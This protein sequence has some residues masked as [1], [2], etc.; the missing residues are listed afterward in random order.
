[1]PEHMISVHPEKLSL[2][3]VR[4]S[5]YVSAYFKMCDGIEVSLCVCLSCRKGIMSNPADSA[6]SRWTNKH[7][8]NACKLA[9]NA[10]YNSLKQQIL[11]AKQIIHEPI[12]SVLAPPIETSKPSNFI[13]VWEQLKQQ[14]RLI[15]LLDEAESFM[16]EDYDT[17][18]V[19]DR[20]PIFEF[21]PKDGIEMLLMR[22]LYCRKELN[23][24]KDAKYKMENETDIEMNKAMREIEKLQLQ[25]SNLMDDNKEFY[26][27]MFALEDNNRSLR[28]QVLVLQDDNTELHKRVRQLEKENIRYKN[29]YPPLQQEEIHEEQI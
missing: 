6:G 23:K 15:P 16:K 11:D 20:P 9:H 13:D 19:D 1:M 26:V 29:T 8:N 4:Y 7:E 22:L 3:P 5:H 27:K 18:D 25:L 17:T 12:P 21:N 10:L 14:K 24:L 28:Q 2:S